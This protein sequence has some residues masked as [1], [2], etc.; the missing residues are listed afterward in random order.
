MILKIQLYSLQRRRKGSRGRL[1]GEG[2]ALTAFQYITP[3][4]NMCLLLTP[5]GAA[6]GKATW[7]STTWT[8]IWLPVTTSAAATTR[9]WSRVSNKWTRSSRRLEGLEVSGWG[10]NSGKVHFL[11]SES[12]ACFWVK[13]KTPYS[14]CFVGLNYILF[15]LVAHRWKTLGK[16]YKLGWGF[17]C[18]H[19]QEPQTG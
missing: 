7:N 18:K 8:E 13:P 9:N 4:P 19:K 12:K 2:W 17:F 5:P 10:T 1:G 6:C 11:N 16:Q 14:K 15:S 3:L